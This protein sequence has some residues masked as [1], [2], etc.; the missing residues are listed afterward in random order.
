MT[1]KEL[2]N[3]YIENQ[4]EFMDDNID[5]KTDNYNVDKD[6]EDKDNEDDDW[7]DEIR[8]GKIDE[9]M[10]RAKLS[11]NE[12]KDCLEAF[13][14]DIVE[15]LSALEEER[16]IQAAEAKQKLREKYNDAKDFGK[17]KYEDIK[18]FSKEKYA[19]F[20]DFSK[21]SYHDIK[22]KMNNFSARDDVGKACKKVKDVV[23]KPV[24]IPKTGKKLPAGI[25]GAGAVSLLYPLHKSKVL[26]AL[27]IATIGAW[28]VGKKVNNE[29]V[30]T[31]IKSA[32]DTFSRNVSD[33]FKGLAGDEDNCFIITV[34]DDFQPKNIK[35]Q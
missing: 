3:D 17:E 28:A 23:G 35:H 21:E 27:G 7:N 10:K 14:Y 33:S 26:A 18:D 20:K 8:L 12:A 6:N 22:R 11:F 24:E 9:V 2:N 19:D 13:D 1:K 16:R 34:D 31:N 29:E 30:K 32:V 4:K 15:T 5:N 25:L